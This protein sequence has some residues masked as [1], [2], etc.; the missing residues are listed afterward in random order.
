MIR[1]NV[2]PDGLNLGHNNANMAYLY[3]ISDFFSVMFEDTSAVNLLLESSTMAASE[4]YSRFLQLT[5]TISL[6]SIQ[7]TTGSQVKLV[8][9]NS[10]DAI[11]GTTEFSLPDNYTYTRYIANRPL[12]PTELLENDVDYS[13]IQDDT[14]SCKIRFAQPLDSYAISSR[15][16]SDGTTK[17]YALWFVDAQLDERLVSNYFGNLIG[18]S[19]ENSTETFANFVYGLFYM[20]VQGPSLTTLRKGLNLALGIPLARMTETVIDIRTYLQTDQFIVITDQNQYLIPYGLQP[21]VAVGATLNVGDEIASWVEIKDYTT[22]GDWW[23]NLYIPNNVIPTQPPG[24]NTRYATAGSELDFVMRNYLKTHTFLVNVNVTTFKSNQQFTQLFD[25]IKKA[26]PSATQ[27][28]YIW[29]VKSDEDVPV[30]DTFSVGLSSYYEEDGGGSYEHMTRNSTKPL[31]RGKSRFIRF[32]APSKIAHAIGEDA[33]LNSST[34]TLQNRSIRGYS[35]TV[36]QF[37]P[38][39]I[40]E[41][42]WI[43][44]LSTR[45]SDTWHRRRDQ[46]SFTRNVLTADASMASVTTSTLNANPTRLCNL[47]KGLPKDARVVPLTVISQT[48]IEQKC[49]A[50]GITPPA[51]DHNF[52]TLGGSPEDDSLNSLVIDGDPSSLP[53]TSLYPDFFKRDVDLTRTMDLNEEMLKSFLPAKED[54]SE[55]DVLVGFRITCELISLTLFSR[56]TGL[57]SP[58]VQLVDDSMD[59]FSADVVSVPMRGM[60]PHNSPFYM[61]R[62]NIALNKDTLQ[63]PAASTADP[64]TAAAT[65]LMNAGVPQ[66]VRLV[67]LTLISDKE[68]YLKCKEWSVAPPDLSQRFYIMGAPA[69]TAPIDGVAVNAT[70]PSSLVPVPLV[71]LVVDPMTGLVTPQYTLYPDLFRRDSDVPVYKDYTRFNLYEYFPRQSEISPGDSLFIYQIDKGVIALYWISTGTSFGATEYWTLQYSPV[72]VLDRVSAFSDPTSIN[73]VPPYSTTQPLLTDYNNY[74]QAVDSGMINADLNLDNAAFTYR[75]QFNPQLMVT[76]GGMQLRHRIQ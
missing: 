13:I 56:N 20:Y 23:L 55:F 11:T 74:D 75:D 73:I 34:N 62:G 45:S 15:L 4:I 33:Y 18:L 19:P 37:R 29:S 14:G 68:F 60:A 5:S 21:S 36:S 46:I 61:S 52:F 27:P 57:V 54:L 70:A 38:N 76:R 12:A 30:E 7:T 42:S 41:A 32:N 39:T 53:V 58:S 17:Q 51:R 69:Q 26:K 25:I 40:E 67:P 49:A 63:G 16:L 9:L 72:P 6:E 48:E 66:S 2:S 22:D 59:A 8:L 43:S 28:I 47:F 31:L 24:Q 44:A 50:Y 65:F 10:T 35:N 64:T 3:G 1:A 71:S